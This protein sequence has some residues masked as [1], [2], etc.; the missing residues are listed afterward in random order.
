MERVFREVIRQRHKKPTILLVTDN[1]TLKQM[2]CDKLEP[3]FYVETA[4]NGLEALEV[5]ISQ[6]KDHF[7]AVFIN[8][9]LPIMDGFETCR[10]ILSHLSRATLIEVV[11]IDS[12]ASK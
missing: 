7:D 12:S 6:P 11:D 8:L 3:H 4:D 5:V 1:Y 10:K 2:I 9:K